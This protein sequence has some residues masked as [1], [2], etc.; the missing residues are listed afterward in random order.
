MITTTSRVQAPS[1]KTRLT[2]VAEVKPTPVPDVKTLKDAIPAHCFER[3]MIRS[4]SYVV[5]DL[6]IVSALFYS[7]V[8]LSRLDAPLYVTVPLWA[9]YSFVQG[10][11]F[12]GLWILAH[13]CGH[14]SF[15]ANLTVNAVTGWFLHSIL[16]VPFFSWKFSHARHH[17]Y[18]NHMEKDTVFVPHR[19]SE[20]K[21]NPTILQKIVDHTAADTPIVTVAALIFHQ[22]LGWPAYILMNAG[23]GPKSLTKSDRATSS[24]YKQSHL[25]P[26]AHV[27]TPSEAPFVA[28][29][30]VGLLLTT[31]ALYMASKSVGLST[32]LLAYG[33][34]YLWMNHWIV[35]ITYLHHTHPEAP[36]YE[37]EDWTF[38]KGAASTVDRE[39][40]FIGRHIFHGIIEYHVVHHMFPRIPFYHA[41]EATWAIA[42]LLGERYIQQ[43]S[44]FFG[45][46]WQSFTS[47][48]YVEPGTGA[49]AGGLVWAKTQ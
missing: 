19:Q 11:F 29:S 17:R 40:G 8:Q 37:A 47:C 49:H 1:V 10:C 9:L 31:G 36:H 13:D 41:E 43:K 46:L 14:D 24:A 26:T 22:V 23:A 20:A 32:V 2:A 45:D 16:M 4:F 27:F 7:A 6:I 38:I 35:A 33:L 28:L 48:K 42:P 3:S 18:H 34:P 39:F 5:R 12:T 30:N 21:T 44:N 25:D 15:S